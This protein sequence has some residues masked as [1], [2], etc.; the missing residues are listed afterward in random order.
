MSN[1]V[2]LGRLKA[3]RIAIYLH[4]VDPA[5]PDQLSKLYVRMLD[6]ILRFKATFGPRVKTLN[7]EE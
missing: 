6:K 3:S 2:M 4:D 1:Y 5:D 7:L